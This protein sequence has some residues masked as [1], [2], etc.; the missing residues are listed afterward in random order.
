MFWSRFV[1]KLNYILFLILFPGSLFSIS[2]YE[3]SENQKIYIK[4]IIL[5][6]LSLMN[7]EEV[8]TIMK[9]DKEQNVF[10]YDIQNAFNN[11]SKSGFLKN[12]N[13]T[14]ESNQEGYNI[15]LT[16][17]E[18]SPLESIK[19]LDNK[20]LDLTILKKKLKDNNIEIG[21]AFSSVALEQAID[22]FNIF[23]QNFGIFLYDVTYKIITKDDIEKI[24]GKFLFD[25]EEI[26]KKGIHIIV[27]IKEIP[28]VFI[29]DI[30]F[31]NTT[32][33]YLEI[34]N[35][36]KLKKDTII[37]KDNDLFFMYKRLRRLGFF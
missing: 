27:Y 18:N 34:L 24:G 11:L 28:R 13:Y 4:E 9:I 26:T 5:N 25:Q 17:E 21:K 37:D 29:K 30:K 23:N 10:V 15:I 22:D 36:I 35:V 31:T 19:V 2:L 6:G 14:I 1:K 3:F 32:I 8:I 7:R 16:L 33:S 12:V 20:L